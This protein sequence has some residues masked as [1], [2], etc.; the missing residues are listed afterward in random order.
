MFDRDNSD[1]VTRDKRSEL[2]LENGG[3]D[4]RLIPIMRSTTEGIEPVL[5]TSTWKKEVDTKGH[6]HLVKQA[7]TIR[8]LES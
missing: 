5:N 7:T 6:R 4:S 2:M 8:V 3:P 1:N